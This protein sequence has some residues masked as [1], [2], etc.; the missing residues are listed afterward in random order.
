M[1][2]GYEDTHTYDAIIMKMTFCFPVEMSDY[3]QNLNILCPQFIMRNVLVKLL[4]IEIKLTKMDKFI[5][6]K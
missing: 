5:G 2:K 3:N 6:V 4:V 1:K